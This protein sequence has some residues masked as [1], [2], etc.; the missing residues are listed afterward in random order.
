MSTF[1]LLQHFHRIIL[2]LLTFTYLLTLAI[3]ASFQRVSASD[4]LVSGE[5]SIDNSIKYT[6]NDL[7]SGLAYQY[8]P[9]LKNSNAIVHCHCMREMR[10][11][12]D[13]FN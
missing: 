11:G 5:I 1:D 3:A 13:R 2:Y 7:F 10:D 12:C 8:G 6:V 4:S 9:Y